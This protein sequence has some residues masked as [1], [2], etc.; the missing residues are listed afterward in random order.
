M[1]RELNLLLLVELICIGCCIFDLRYGKP[2]KKREVITLGISAN[3]EIETKKEE[4]KKEEKVEPVIKE[5]Q[6]NKYTTRITSYW[7]NDECNSEDMTAS[8]KSSK[9]FQLNDKGWYT[10]N[11]KL[12]IAT[13]STRLGSSS[14]KTY[15]LYQE[16][17]LLINGTT[18]QAVVLDVCGACQR[19]NR[20]D[21][22]VKD[23]AHA[24]DQNIEII[25]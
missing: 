16:V 4:P 13:A 11:G 15:K 18:Y 10:W 9:D 2:E 12:V 7:V 24:I 5:Q 20:I 3:I 19:N 23:R 14:Q 21:L 6:I 25:Y 22:F 17:E 8:G 1:K